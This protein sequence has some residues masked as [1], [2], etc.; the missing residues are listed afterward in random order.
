MSR[1]RIRRRANPRSSLAPKEQKEKQCD[2][3]IAGAIV[4]FFIALIAKLIYADSIPYGLF[5][6]FKENRPLAGIAASWPIFLW[7]CCITSFAAFLTLNKREIN[8]K[9]ESILTNGFAISL[10]AGVLE[11]LCFRWAIF[12]GT[13]VIAKVANFVLLGFIGFGLIELLHLWVCG[14]FVNFL[15]VGKMEWL[16]FDQGW[17]VGA[18]VLAANARFRNGHKYLGWF[19]FLNSWILGFFFFWIMFNY[20]LWTAI[21]VH[22]LYDMMIF[23]IAYV[24]AAIERKFGMGT[25]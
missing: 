25:A 10:T 16:I 20:G 14:P 15:T 3:W 2:N 4:C 12:L 18:A 5:D 8:E 1:Y 22:F 9:A 6:F 11:E 19:G 21:L 24:D 17:A 13:I 23:T 7:G